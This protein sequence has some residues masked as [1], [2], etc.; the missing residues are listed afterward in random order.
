M[1]HRFC[2]VYA[3]E[4]KVCGNTS[5]GIVGRHCEAKK[6]SVKRADVQAQKSFQSFH[7]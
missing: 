3:V 7:R 2:D 6:E 5:S 4:N 1:E